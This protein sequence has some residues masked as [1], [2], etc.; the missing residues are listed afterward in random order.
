MLNWN[1][2]KLHVIVTYLL[3]VLP[4]KSELDGACGEC[5]SLKKLHKN[6]IG[7]KDRLSDPVLTWQEASQILCLLVDVQMTNNGMQKGKF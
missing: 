3:T 2:I 5:L 4:G 1:F 6:L 7:A